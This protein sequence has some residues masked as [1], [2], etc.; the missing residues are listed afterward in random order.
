MGAHSERAESA[1]PLWGKGPECRSGDGH[2]GPV[3]PE[4]PQK[5]ER[6][7]ESSSFWRN[8][9]GA[10][11]GRDWHDES[12]HIS[13]HERHPLL[14]KKGPANIGSPCRRGSEPPKDV[15]SGQ[16]ART[17]SVGVAGTHSV[18]CDQRADVAST[19][20]VSLNG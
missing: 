7:V 18:L 12:V 6:E 9:S 10:E 11:G 4:Y 15:E 19:G 2:R 1:G 5:P 17:A 13:V 8:R 20:D 14:R 16:C 3:G